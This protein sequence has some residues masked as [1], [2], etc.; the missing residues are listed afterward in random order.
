MQSHQRRVIGRGCDDYGAAAILRSEN[1][2]DE[3]LHFAS[4]LADQRDDDDIRARVASHH[5]QQHAL[6]DTA[7]GKQAD[8]LAATD[9]QERVDRAHPHIQRLR[10]GLSLQRVDGPASEAH[11]GFTVDWAQAV[12]RRRGSVYDSSEKL[13][14]DSDRSGALTRHDTGA[15]AQS[16]RVACRHQ[17]QPVAGEPDD[18]G[19]DA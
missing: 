15:G 8:A 9:G 2:L 13:G 7:S 3:F 4:A 17:E 1:A 18:L 5:S 12:E 19:F 6:A 14:P 11:R 10:D 16:V